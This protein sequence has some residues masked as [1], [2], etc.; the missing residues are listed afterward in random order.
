MKGPDF[1]LTSVK[2]YRLLAKKRLPPF[3]F[4]FIDGGA[5]NEVTMGLNSSDYQ[6]IQL[7]KRVLK[8]VAGV[9]TGT[10][11]LGQKLSL[12]IVL[13][14]IG[15]AGVYARRGEVQAAKAA[16]Q[17]GVPFSLSTV[18]ICSID[19][20]SQATREP[21]WYQFY[22][23]KDKEV[24]RQLLK[25]AEDASC[26]VLLVTVDLPA[27]G[28]RHRYNRSLKQN[29]QSLKHPGWFY[30]VRLRGG[31]LILGDIATLLPH[32]KDLPSM[33]KWVGSQLNASMAWADLDW[34]RSH[35]PHKIV[36]KGIMD[37][38][39][40]HLAAEHGLDAI[41]VSNHGAR[42]LD[43][44]PST[45]SLLPHI[46]EKVDGRLEVLIDGGISSGLDIVKALALGANACLIG[47]AWAFAL[48][49]RGEAG[50]SEV[51]G[52]LQN[53]LKVAMVQL[54]VTHIPEIDRNILLEWRSL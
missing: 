27:I 38:E 54:G 35:W 44:T 9:D 22:M 48:A 33:R 43:S 6:A 40:A 46:V 15:F 14:P 16:K 32:L 51:L 53:E 45:I 8:N 37:G 31:P 13:A 5:F 2:D 41:V 25:R 3:L 20:V 47:R 11:I 21:F 23:L 18:S 36:L 4:D 49:A 17:A 39:D 19:E 10:T 29:F 7:K 24:A 1:P 42:H 50:V 52:L 26:R 28:A 12:P 34:I 30:D